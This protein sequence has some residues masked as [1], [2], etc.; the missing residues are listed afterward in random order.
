MYDGGYRPEKGYY[1]CA[2]VVG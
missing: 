2:R 1:K